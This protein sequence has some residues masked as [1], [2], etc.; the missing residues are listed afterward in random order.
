VP[1]HLSRVHCKSDEGKIQTC[2]TK[3]V[4]N[5]VKIYFVI[6]YL[7]IQ[8]V[9]L[10]GFFPIGWDSKVYLLLDGI[11]STQVDDGKGLFLGG[12]SLIFF[13]DYSV[14]KKSNLFNFNK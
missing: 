7:T 2:F 5:T 10:G 6:C 3:L 12:M 4:C 11:A 1:G 14:R 9:K 8:L 13:V